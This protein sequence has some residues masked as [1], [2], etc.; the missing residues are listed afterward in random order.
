MIYSVAVEIR[1]LEG[2]ADPEGLT[3]ERALPVLGFAGVSRV[4]VGKLVRFDLEAEDEDHALAEAHALCDRLLA[5]PVIEQA[6]VH[7]DRLEEPR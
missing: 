4:R 5:N 2:V 3:I 6:E 7:L 1:P